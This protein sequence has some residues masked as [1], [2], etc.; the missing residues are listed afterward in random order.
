MSANLR[1]LERQARRRTAA[2][3]DAAAAAR[4]IGVEL[5]RAQIAGERVNVAHVADLAGVTRVTV[6]AWMAAVTEEDLEAAAPNTNPAGTENA[7]QK[8]P[9]A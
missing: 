4:A 9:T 1:L 3:E 8:G 2:I 7:G 5:R 6:Y